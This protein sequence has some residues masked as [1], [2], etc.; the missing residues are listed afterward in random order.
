MVLFPPVGE[1]FK[2][3][4]PPLRVSELADALGC[5]RGYIHKL[6]EAGTV[7]VWK[8]GR[9]FRVPVQ[10]AQKL[11]REAGVLRDP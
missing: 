8:V 7:K 2:D 1:R 3:G 10:E 9:V 6:I 5:S 11:A 4:Q